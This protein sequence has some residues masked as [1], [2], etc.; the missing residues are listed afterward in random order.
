MPG[1]TTVFP[2][3]I[4]DISRGNNECFHDRGSVKDG[5][6]TYRQFEL[7]FQLRTLLMNDKLYA[8]ACKWVPFLPFK[9]LAKKIIIFLN[10]IKNRDV[11][12]FNFIEY[13]SSEKNVP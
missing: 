12:M 6:E 9:G 13:L 7:K 11:R 4:I 2:K 3:E 8:F 5:I 1:T 10:G